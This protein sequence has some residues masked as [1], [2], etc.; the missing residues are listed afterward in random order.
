MALQSSQ[1]FVRALKSPSDPP[2][3]GGPLKIE[4]AQSVWNNDFFYVPSKA[5]VVA[6]WVLSKFLKEKEKEKATNPLADIRYWALLSEVIRPQDRAPDATQHRPVKTWLGAILGRVPIVP[7]VSSLLRLYKQYQ[8]IHQELSGVVVPCLSTL[9]PIGI[10]RANADSLLECFGAVLS[11]LP[12]HKS[13][14]EF[15]KMASLVTNSYRV[16]LGNSSNKRKLYNLFV[17]HHLQHWIKC[18]IAGE[19]TPVLDDVY[20]TGIETLFSFDVLRHLH[21]QKLENDLFI[22]FHK[23]NRVERDAL[24]AVLP[25]IFSSFLQVINRHRTSLFTHTSNAS[26]STT[27]NEVHTSAMR[28]FIASRSLLD[29]AT[30]PIEAWTA[31][32]GLLDIVKEENL[33]NRSYPDAVSALNQVI[34][35]AVNGL[36]GM[37]HYSTVASEIPHAVDCLSTLAQ[38]DCDLILPALPRILPKLLLVTFSKCLSASRA[39]L[40]HL[41]DYHSKTRTIHLHISNLL[42]ITFTPKH[43]EALSTEP[44]RIYQTGFESVYLQSAYLDR[45]AKMVQGFVT[46]AQIV[47]LAKVVIGSLKGAWE[48][49]E[50][51]AR[52]IRSEKKMKEVSNT[53]ETVNMHPD[54][55]A[56]RF[57][58]LAMLAGVVL[59]SLPVRSL[60]NE[61]GRTSLDELILDL[62][63]RFI[64]TVVG[65]LATK[66]KGHPCEELW[67]WQVCAAAALRMGYV[68]DVPRQF[69]NPTTTG[70]DTSKLFKRV[71]DLMANGDVLPE[72]THETFRYLFS[73]SPARDSDETQHV[74]DQ[75][76]RY[77]ER[78]LSVADSRWSGHPH[79]LTYDGRGKADSALALLHLLVGRWLPII[80][81]CAT[82]QQLKQFVDTLMNMD[83]SDHRPSTTMELSPQDILISVLFS[84]EFWELPNIRQVVMSYITEFTSTLDGSLDNPIRTQSIQVSGIYRILLRFPLEYLTK[85]CRNDLVK[86]ALDTDLFLSN[87]TDTDAVQVM[88][89]LRVFLKRVFAY[90]GYVEPSARGAAG[91]LEHLMTNGSDVE[92]DR[93]FVDATLDLIG[94]YFLE[95]LKLAGKGNTDI[96]KIFNRFQEW[97]FEQKSDLRRRGVIRMIETMTVESS[98]S[99]LSH[100]LQTRLEK[101]YRQILSANLHE[102][103]EIEMRATSLSSDLRS[104]NLWSCLLSLRGWLGAHDD[105]QL[106]GLELA[107]K[108]TVSSSNVSLNEIRTIVFAILL[109]ELLCLPE[110]QQAAHIGKII[111]VYV[112]FALVLKSDR[113]QLDIHISK[114]C[115]TI[116]AQNYAYMLNI[117]SDTMTKHGECQVDEL[118]QFVYL[119]TRLLK[120]YPQNTLK[121]TQVF[122]TNCIN[123]FSSHEAFVNGPRDLCIYVLGYVLQLCSERP[124][125]LRTSDLSG[126]WRLLSKYLAPSP[127]HDG[128]TNVAIFHRIVSIVGAL[129]RLRRDLIT[130]T[131]PH[132][133]MVLQQ[134]MLCMRGCRPMLGTKQTTIVMSSQ[135]RWISAK[136]SLEVEEAKALSR[137]LE[138]LGTKTIIRTHISLSGGEQKAQS[139]A[140]PFSKHAVYVIKAYIECMNDPLCVLSL[141]I[142]RELQPGLFVLCGMVSDYARNAMMVS[143]LDGGGKILMKGLWRDYEKQKYVGKAFLHSTMTAMLA[144][145]RS[146]SNRTRQCLRS[147]RY[148][149]TV[150]PLIIVKPPPPPPPKTQPTPSPSTPGRPIGAS[151]FDAQCLSALGSQSGQTQLTTL[152]SQYIQ[153]SGTALDRVHLPYESRPTEGRRVSSRNSKNV[154]MV[155][156]CAT[157]GYEHKVTLSSGFL[158]DTSPVREGEC[159]VLTCAHTL[160]EAK[161]LSS[162]NWQSG[163]FVVTSSGSQRHPAFHP[164]S[165]VA[166]SIPRSDLILLSCNLPKSSSISLPVS[167]YPAPRQTKI[168]A[169]FV[170]HQKPEEPDWS[171][172]LGGTWS[173]WVAGEVLG[174]RD[175]AGRESE[176]GTYDALS[177][178]LFSPPPTNGS[179]GGPIVD[180]ESGAV[181]GMVAGTRM[182]NRV[183]GL[184]G[185]GIP[186]EAIFEMF[187]LPGLDGKN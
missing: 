146:Y 12:S 82:V 41:L 184:R 143:A 31:M 61:A 65:K 121:Y 37:W 42:E 78:W 118:V 45:L 75:A 129:V 99:S 151:L 74:I 92:V 132:L 35:L 73:K 20:N 19:P 7:V 52:L 33:F 27:V 85:S 155:A 4:I 147:T 109:Q 97:A 80:D 44:K 173:K 95:L 70:Y 86:K 181:V 185:W 15:L 62:K 111:S 140:K 164:V 157:N 91:Y 137:L 59:S 110:D 174:Y 55:L 123:T 50:N 165:H 112:S 89:V 133:G 54:A 98:F 154:V 127:S 182:D 10:Q 119:A 76:L 68:L 56:V 32:N 64:A 3:A 28:F 60:P 25:R 71:T 53:S 36:S 136:Q 128:V 14:E 79:R 156:H 88:T 49:T 177:H 93:V 113:E 104:M 135:P 108:V 63:S 114:A 8:C 48:D 2:T 171:P 162:S 144:L 46:S 51:A 94:F 107:S 24:F 122:T 163:S 139:L 40:D 172:W 90:T 22:A 72:L 159:I 100:E 148:Y 101:V 130:L 170:V 1:D 183:E 13:D 134:L 83:I 43:V 178:M 21:D 142:R 87:D 153:T 141:D 11:L 167:P 126:I 160:E 77:V 81:S 30:A 69:S 5:E 149:A 38:I 186:A 131:L 150:F 66:M 26:S 84:A 152:I 47:P 179:S 125:A 16:S 58:L 176:P 102:M 120:D 138:T 161:S 96:T 103:S 117:V 39:F 6:D 23:I 124:A 57:S 180:E 158:L 106:F 116:S 67:G 166:C 18:A 105:N 115:K 29:S 187:A 175:F 169:H 34:D 9:W 17:Q 168:R 145:R